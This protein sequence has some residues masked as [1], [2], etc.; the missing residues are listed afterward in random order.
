M[1]TDAQVRIYM[2]RRSKGT[3]QEKAAAYAGMSA[4]TAR[5]YE[6]AG[7]LPSELHV[8]HDWSSRPN[9]FAEDWPWVVEQLER[10][11]A[12]QATTL[13][14]LLCEL[15]PERYAP[16]QLRTLQRHIAD[17]RALHGPE[18]E[19]I[20]AQVH[21]P[22]EAAQSDFTHMEDLG[23]TLAGEAS[24]HL[25]FH[26]VLTYSNMEAVRIC[27]GESFEALA[28][29]IEA[30]LWQFGGVPQTHRTD[31]LGAAI[32][33]LS[34]DEQ[35]AFKERYAALMRHYGMRPTMNNTGVAHENG[36]VEQSH[37]QL[38][39]AIDQALRV[40]G[41]RDFPSRAAYESWLHALVRRRNDTRAARC[42]TERAVLRPLPTAPLAPC[43]DLRLTVSR[44]S[45]LIVLGNTYSVPSRLVGTSVLVRLRAEYVE[46]YVGSQLAARMPRLHGRG[47]HA[48]HYQHLI[49]SLVRK[50]GAFAQYRYRD[51]LFPT[52]RFRTAYDQLAAHR[53]SRADAE[54]LHLLHLAASTSEREVDAALALLLEQ[55]IV[56]T[57]D[58]VRSLTQAPVIP[59]LPPLVIDFAPYDALLGRATHG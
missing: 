21:E 59:Q 28:E 2:R 40:R 46:V 19:V 34:R 5:R 32:H 52:V 55:G 51:D 31:H 29:G 53:A 41:S 33:P 10:D 35:E 50:P 27:F 22:G 47:Q 39:R 30:A 25:L 45:T 1:K 16:T 20:F 58:D 11:R 24:P 48:I 26:C 9:P 14:R 23:I 8:P 3:S 15:H 43:R 56:P 38:K 49:W 12:L 13:F 17:W 18:Q 42:A 6:R 54:Y 4:S 37:W 44:F 57:L 7:K 36:D